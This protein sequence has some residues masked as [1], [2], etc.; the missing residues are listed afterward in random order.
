MT[1]VLRY[2]AACAN[3]EVFKY[4]HTLDDMNGGFPVW[5]PRYLYQ[6]LTAQKHSLQVLYIGYWDIVGGTFADVYSLLVHRPVLWSFGPLVGFTQLREIDIPLGFF[7]Q[8]PTGSTQQTLHLGENLPSS[9]EK[10]CLAEIL[11]RDFAVLASEL[12]TMLSSRAVRFPWLAGIEL[13][14]LSMFPTGRQGIWF[15]NVL[16]D[17][18]EV[19]EMCG[20]AG[21]QLRF[22]SYK[23][24]RP[25]LWPGPDEDDYLF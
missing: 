8:Y 13:Y 23:E 22:S 16:D 4:E 17:F 14:L 6:A 20:A 19:Q 1:N 12:C 24:S 18:E 3:L 9:V 2:I 10:L 7:L 21:I 5:N 11:D 25:K 15:E